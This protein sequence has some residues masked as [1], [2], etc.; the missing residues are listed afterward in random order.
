MDIRHILSEVDTDGTTCNR[1]I[2]V[3]DGTLVV[4]SGNDLY[5]GWRVMPLARHKTAAERD[6]DLPPDLLEAI[7]ASLRDGKVRYT[8]PLERTSFDEP[9]AVHVED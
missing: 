6:V 1:D 5:G 2:L 3:V 4:F 7:E 8:D 9:L